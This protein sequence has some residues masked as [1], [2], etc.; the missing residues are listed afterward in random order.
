MNNEILILDDNPVHRELIKVNIISEMPEL[1]IS[2]AFNPKD[3]IKLISE[4]K[5]DLI[6]IDYNMPFMTGLDFLKETRDIRNNT[7]VIM[8]TGEGDEE[9]AAN[10]FKL[11]ATDYLVKTI[12]LPLRIPKIIKDI[13]GN[14]GETPHIFPDTTKEECGMDQVQIIQKNIEELS[15]DISTKEKIIIEFN[16]AKEFN[17]FSKWV[18][19]QK[20]VNID[21]IDFLGAKYSIIVT[22]FPRNID[23]II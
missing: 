9:I 3:A 18:K 21:K 7:P 1:K 4:K 5:F 11:G 17:E 16:S 10:A 12:D 2:E 15:L 20:N 8:L 22:I 23:K 19:T 6:L 13:L 14:P